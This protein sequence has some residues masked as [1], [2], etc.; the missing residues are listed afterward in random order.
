MPRSRAYKNEHELKKKIFKTESS[1]ISSLPS[2]DDTS[3]LNNNLNSINT[4]RYDMASSTQIDSNNLLEDPSDDVI[5]PEK[6]SDSPIERSNL[7]W[8]AEEVIFFYCELIR[9]GFSL[10]YIV[11]LS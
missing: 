2:N 1:L 8:T 9:S 6:A 7:L 11:L 5:S 10:W 3:Y 4:E